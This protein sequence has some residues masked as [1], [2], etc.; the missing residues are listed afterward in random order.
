MKK[1]MMIMAA[2]ILMCTSAVAQT[3]K[4]TVQKKQVQKTQVKTDQ[5]QQMVKELGLNDT[6]A[7]KLKTLNEKYAKKMPQCSK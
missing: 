2:A 6:Q 7:A 3:S 5:T 4:K 1:I